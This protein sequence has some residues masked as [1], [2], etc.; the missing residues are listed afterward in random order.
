[1]TKSL[2]ALCLFALLTSATPVMAEKYQVD[3]AHS[4]INFNVEHLGLTE[5]NGRFT[6]FTGTFNFVPGS[7]EGSVEFVVQAK[8]INTDVEKRDEHL[9]NADFFDVAKYPTLS[10]KSTRVTHLADERYQVDGKLTIHGVTKPITAS[11]RI[12]GPKE[13]MG[14]EKIG[15]RTTF[16]INRLHYKVGDG[17]K[18]NSDAV[19]D[20]NVFIEVKGEANLLGGTEKKEPEKVETPAQPEAPANVEQPEKSDETTPTEE[21]PAE[22]PSTDEASE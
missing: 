18:F 22:A 7:N 14:T 19:I 17:E 15:F 6:D 12:I 21:A 5:I 8:S 20:H 11:A 1:M 3:P 9:R 13:A 16:K 10:F 2:R 4:S